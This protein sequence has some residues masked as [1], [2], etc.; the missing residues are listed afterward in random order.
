M[1][2]YLAALDI[3]I[4]R[5]INRGMSC[6]VFDHTMPFVTDLHKS[7]LAVAALFIFVVSWVG[8][9]GKKAFMI[10]T[11]I[12]LATGVADLVNA[13]V[14]KQEFKRLRP[15]YV[16]NDV[17]LRSPVH[18]GYSFPSNHATNCF[19]IAT[20]VACAI[21][22]FGFLAFFGALV[23]AFSRVYV[24][25]HFPLDVLGSALVGI[26]MGRLIWWLSKGTVERYEYAWK[27]GT[28][29]AGEGA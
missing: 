28:N 8:Y 13:L 9:K 7:P 2:K 11:V 26:I 5:I 4:F 16:L 24:G 23:I 15:T 10:V 18:Y 17:A 21:P 3:K 14:I 25:V 19:T 20:V 6:T 29:T 27:R 12:V 22:E 1:L